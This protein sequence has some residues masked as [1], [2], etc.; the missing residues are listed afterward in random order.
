M[1]GKRRRSWK[2]IV[3]W[4]IVGLVVVFAVM[5]AVPYGRSSH[6]N[7]PVANAFVWV[8]SQAEAIAKKSC[9]DCHSNETNWW[10]ATY[11]APFSWLV[12][13]DVDAGRA[14]LN[15]SDYQ[16][17]PSVEGFQ[18]GVDEMPP[19]QYTIIHPGTKLS[20]AQRQ[21]LA[22]GYS[23]S[24]AANQG[25]SGGSQG[26]PGGSTSTTVPSDAEAQAL[27]IIDQACSGCHSTDLALNY[28]A[29]SADQA[30]AL[31]DDMVRRGAQLTAE[32]EQVLIQYFTR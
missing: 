16:G 9:Y 11:I 21:T 22:Q 26:Q 4:V 23:E 20:D 12:Q 1:A 31:I 3:L 28:R 24:L 27:A 10:W 8:D 14:R 18:H 6:T 30:Q 29:S 2:K 32:Q 5:Q 19:W 17:R 13:H 25:T 15:F 7:P